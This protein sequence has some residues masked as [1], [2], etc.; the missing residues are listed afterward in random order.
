MLDGLLVQLNG[1]RFG[2]ICS[3]SG[4]IYRKEDMYN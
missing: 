4:G 1:D 2:G 3:A